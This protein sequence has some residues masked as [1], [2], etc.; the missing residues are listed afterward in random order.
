MFAARAGAKHVY[1][2]EASDLAGRTRDNVAEN[3]L[4]NAI[5]VIQARVEEVNLPVKSVDIIISEWMVRFLARAA[6]WPPAR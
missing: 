5:T 6:A 4:Q 1:A 3:G 2:I